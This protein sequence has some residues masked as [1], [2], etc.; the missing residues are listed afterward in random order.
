MCRKGVSIY[1]FFINLLKFTLF[2][3]ICN[4]IFIGIELN[5]ALFVAVVSYSGPKL[6][7]YIYLKIK[8]NNLQQ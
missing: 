3:L 2:F 5:K 8:S 6:I 7:D 1:E 4:Y